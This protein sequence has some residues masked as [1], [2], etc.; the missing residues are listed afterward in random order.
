MLRWF[1]PA[2]ILLS[3]ASWPAQSETIFPGRDLTEQGDPISWEGSRT[4]F[5]GHYTWPDRE[6]LGVY[7]DGAKLVTRPDI[8]DHRMRL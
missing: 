7:N 2:L 4:V 6:P 1:V 5:V 3:L 8:V